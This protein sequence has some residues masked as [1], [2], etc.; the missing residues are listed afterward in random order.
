MDRLEEKYKQ[1]V[2]NNH[3][4]RLDMTK[5]YSSSRLNIQLLNLRDK[6]F[7]NEYTDSDIPYYDNELWLEYLMTPNYKS[8][9]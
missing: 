9:N 1:Y 8:P 4:E 3:I 6:F 5:Q 2:A 7:N